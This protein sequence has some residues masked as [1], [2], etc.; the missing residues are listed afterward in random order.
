[1]RSPFMDKQ[2]LILHICYVFSY[3]TKYHMIFLVLPYNVCD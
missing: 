3:V 2:G 1:M